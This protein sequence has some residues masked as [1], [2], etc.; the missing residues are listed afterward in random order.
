M[1]LVCVDEDGFRRVNNREALALIY[2]FEV[3]VGKFLIDTIRIE[4]KPNLPPA[5]WSWFTEDNK[6]GHVPPFKNTTKIKL[7]SDYNSEPLHWLGVFIHE[8]VH[9]WQTNTWLNI[10]DPFTQI[11]EYRESQ[12]N[13]IDGLGLEP[14]AA[15]VEDW[16]SLNY[17]IET[18]LEDKDEDAADRVWDAINERITDHNYQRTTHTKLQDLHRQINHKYQKVL[19]RIRKPKQ[20]RR[21]IKPFVRD[22]QILDLKVAKLE[23]S[24]PGINFPSFATDH[25]TLTG[26]RL[27]ASISPPTPGSRRVDRREAMA[28]VYTFGGQ[29]GSS[30]IDAIE[31]WEGTADISG[32][33][34]RMILSPEHNSEDLKWLGIF[35]RKAARIWQQRTGRHATGRQWTAEGEVGEDYYH[36]HLQSLN[37]NPLQHEKAVQ[38]WFYV[39]YH[40]DYCGTRSG[41]NS[42]SLRDIQ[43]LIR[44][45]IGVGSQAE[46]SENYLLRF[47]KIYY[48]RLIEELRD[49]E[50]I[51]HT[52]VGPNYP[53]PF[54]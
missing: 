16:F 11:Y 8:A 52:S 12:L 4:Y 32:S 9:I 20:P 18:C 40:F 1:E 2:T 5:P 17:A 44:E 33:T 30:L 10:K 41:A 22:R 15:V 37:L 21:K 45:V 19:D 24:G 39:N 53:N 35:I 48:A 3:E 46:L 29:V 51:P 26:P 50:L 27:D 42:M 47:T 28:L 14:F 54:G 43:N 49:P 25:I 31:I 36:M 38:D 7:R 13:S 23:I 34:T 6:P